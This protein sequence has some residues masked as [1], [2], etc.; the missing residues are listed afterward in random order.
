MDNALA[1]YSFYVRPLR[2]ILRKLGYVKRDE[3]EAPPLL[4]PAYSFMF[5]NDPPDPPA[6]CAQ[7]STEQPLPARL[8][9]GS[10]PA[11]TGVGPYPMPVPYPTS[12]TARASKP[13]PIPAPRIKPPVHLPYGLDYSDGETQIMEAPSV[14]AK[15]SF[16]DLKPRK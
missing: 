1:A 6:D 12:P 13:P 2:Y 5:R 15:P 10:E 8:R 9:L 16:M 14:Q 3:V 11:H 4:L 7:G